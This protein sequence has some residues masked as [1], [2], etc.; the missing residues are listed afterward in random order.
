MLSGWERCQGRCKKSRWD[1]RS[2]PHLL[3][4]IPLCSPQPWSKAR[5]R[6]SVVLPKYLPANVDLLL[7]M[8]WSL[9]S[10]LPD[11]TPGLFDTSSPSTSLGWIPIG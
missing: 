6:R 1:G 5:I 4:R 3:I 8:V 10:P 2:L 7:E 11:E 9:G